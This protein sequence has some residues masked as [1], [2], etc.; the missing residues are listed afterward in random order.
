[1]DDDGEDEEKEQGADRDGH[2]PVQARELEHE[3]VEH[4]ARALD[5]RGR[6]AELLALAQLGLQVLEHLDTSSLSMPE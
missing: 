5:Q 6:V 4:A 1:M 3:E 2:A